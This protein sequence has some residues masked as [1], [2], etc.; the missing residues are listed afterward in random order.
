MLLYKFFMVM[1]AGFV[2]EM[3]FFLKKHTIYLQGS[4]YIGLIMSKQN[5]FRRKVKV[6][7][8]KLNR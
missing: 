4:I 7:F 8:I 1:Q 5:L 2:A 3:I 6:S